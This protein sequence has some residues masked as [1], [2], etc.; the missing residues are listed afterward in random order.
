MERNI[1]WASAMLSAAL[2][3]GGFFAGGRYTTTAVSSGDGYGWVL[4]VDRFTG[5]TTG[6]FFGGAGYRGQCSPVHGSSQ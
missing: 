3:V 1:L 6:R 5:A 4:V 2:L